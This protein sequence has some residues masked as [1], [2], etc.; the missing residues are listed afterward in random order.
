LKFLHLSEGKNSSGSEQQQSQRFPLTETIEEI[1]HAL[2]VSVAIIAV[3]SISLSFSFLSESTLHHYTTIAEAYA[4]PY[5]ETVKHRNL[6]ID[7]GNGLKT[8][9][10][11]TIPAIG[12]GPSLE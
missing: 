12:K 5:V 6:T 10:Q 7:L 8:N 3:C 11:L 1:V 2:H 9:A 4:Q